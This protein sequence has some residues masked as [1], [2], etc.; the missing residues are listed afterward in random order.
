MAKK[1]FCEVLKVLPWFAILMLVGSVV[2]RH[3]CI[4]FTEQVFYGHCIFH[5]SGAGLEKDLN[6]APLSL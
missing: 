4:S 5:S 1:V 6:V 3:D 2:V